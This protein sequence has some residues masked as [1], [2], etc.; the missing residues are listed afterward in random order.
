MTLYVDRQGH[1]I[2][3]TTWLALTARPEYVV[4]ASDAVAVEGHQVQVMTM[5]LGLNLP[6]RPRVFETLL[7]AVGGNRPCRWMWPSL[8]Q[9]QVGHRQVVDE[10]ATGQ[11][12]ASGSMSTR[13]N[14]SR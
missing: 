13:S 12:A 5:W 14:N 9:A 1:V 6:S 7:H 10:L 3:R 4:I 2:K 11:P 8:L